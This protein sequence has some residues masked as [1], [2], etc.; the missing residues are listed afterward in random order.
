LE[1]E[2]MDFMSTAQL[3]GNFGEFVGA[4]AVVATLGYLA[5]QVRH[6]RASTDANTKQL[7]AAMSAEMTSHWLS[8]THSI[9][10]DGEL[11]DI[12]YRMTTAPE[13]VA[14]QESLRLF[15]WTIS[16]L[17]SGE[18]AFHQWQGGNLDDPLW[19]SNHVLLSD[20]FRTPTHPWRLGWPNAKHMYTPAYQ[21]Y[22]ESLIPTNSPT[23]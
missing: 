10:N 18:F 13:S 11:V 20:V 1:E 15:F 16:G 22:I 7:A 4:I 23:R 17:K 9:A 6:S 21:A 12:Y 14:P 2:I 8:N 3:L 5:V 19:E